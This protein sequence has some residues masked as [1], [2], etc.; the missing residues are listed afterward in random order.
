[1]TTIWESS[2]KAMYDRNVNIRVPLSIV[3]FAGVET[4]LKLISQKILTNK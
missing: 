4:T 2:L 3:G 1:M